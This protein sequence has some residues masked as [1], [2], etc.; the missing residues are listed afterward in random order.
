MACAASASGQSAD[1]L[2]AATLHAFDGRLWVRPP[3]GGHFPWVLSLAIYHRLRRRHGQQFCPDCLRRSA[4]VQLSWRLAFLVS[5]RHHG[6]WLHDACPRCDAP[7]LFHRMGLLQPHRLAC[8]QC[9]LNL[10]S[11]STA[12]A[13]QRMLRFQS[14][15]ERA[16]RRGIYSLRQG[17]VPAVEFF[18]GLRLLAGGAFNRRRWVGL[19]DTLPQLARRR[20]P[21]APARFIEHARLPERIFVLDLLRR[22]LQQW[23]D[24][25]AGPAHRAGIYAMRF[26]L[27]ERRPP[28]SWLATGLTE[29]HRRYAT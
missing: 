13:P 20:A 4:S 16:L 19:Q 8:P 26:A 3:Q 17:E 18:G 25:F 9:G 24:S 11:I 2:R 10:L 22:C 1:A 5:C 12:P 28:P 29:L 27:G 23:P 21:I 15:L 7:F 6:C 14:R